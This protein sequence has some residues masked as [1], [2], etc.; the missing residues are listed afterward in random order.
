MS[1]IIKRSQGQSEMQMIA[2]FKRQTQ[3][4]VDEAKERQF[5]KTKAQERKERM[6]YLRSRRWRK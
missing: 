1:V 2:K 3:D 4:I 5:H 6:K